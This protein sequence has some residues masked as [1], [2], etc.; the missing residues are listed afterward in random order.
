[1]LTGP[2]FSSPQVV[3]EEENPNF[4]TQVRRKFPRQDVPLL[5]ACSNG[6]RHS[7]DAL[8]VLE[9][10]GYTC[11]VGLKGGY[12]AFIREFDFKLN[13]R[14]ES[15]GVVSGISRWVSHT[16]SL[17]LVAGLVACLAGGTT[18]IGQCGSQLGIWCQA[19]QACPHG[20]IVGFP[21]WRHASTAA[22]SGL[23][24]G[25]VIATG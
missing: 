8:E 13:P 23:T 22:C 25:H 4:L 7:V 10:A 16:Q 17:G 12:S 15:L 19:Q 2:L 3:E 20:S 21:A 9:E 18:G 6:A 11:L 24:G 1:M 5:V 14:G